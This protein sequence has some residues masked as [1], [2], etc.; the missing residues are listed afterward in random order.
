MDENLLIN[1]EKKKFLTWRI[2]TVVLLIVVVVLTVLYSLG[3]GWKEEKTDNSEQKDDPKES[4][5]T[6]W[7]E[8]SESKKN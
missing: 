5:L 1:D 7:K 4:I 3:V 6:L 8:N 2:S